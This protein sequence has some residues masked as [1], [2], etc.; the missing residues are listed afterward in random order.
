M[1]AAVLAACDAPDV[2]EW[3]ERTKPELLEV[4]EVPD[5]LKELGAIYRNV[6]AGFPGVFPPADASV[7][8][9]SAVRAI[10][11]LRDARA[12]HNSSARARANLDT[13]I[14]WKAEYALR[15]IDAIDRLRP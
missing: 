13:M 7:E 4:P 9:V 14:R 3:F 1:M 12:D 11:D 15:L 6:R 5:H 8:N 10:M 2:P